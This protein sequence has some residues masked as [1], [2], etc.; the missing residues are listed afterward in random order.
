MNMLST[1]FGYME[2]Q[3]KKTDK[4]KTDYKFNNKGSYLFNNQ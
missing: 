1:E 3:E 4:Q 2:H